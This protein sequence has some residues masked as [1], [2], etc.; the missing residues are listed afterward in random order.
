MRNRSCYRIGNWLALLATV[1]FVGWPGLVRGNC[2][3]EPDE[4]IGA[5]TATTRAI[6]CCETEACS[7]ATDLANGVKPCCGNSANHLAGGDGETRDHRCGVSCCQS[8]TAIA[9]NSVQPNQISSVDFVLAEARNEFPSGI[10]IRSQDFPEL[11]LC[12]LPAQEHCA[13]ICSWL[14]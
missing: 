11:P 4:P 2:C 10:G 3:C 5:Q 6:D 8:L 7:T 9:A 12:F 14:K 13:R 1:A